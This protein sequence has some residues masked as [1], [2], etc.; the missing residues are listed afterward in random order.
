MNNLTLIIIFHV[1]LAPL[2]QLFPIVGTVHAWLIFSI[3][4]YYGLT[5]KTIDRL[6]LFTFY[7][8]GAELLWRGFGANVF[9]EFG[10][11]AILVNIIIII[12]RIGINSL[13]LNTGALYLLFLLPSILVIKQF[14]DFNHALLGP[15]VIG[16]SVLLY[17]QLKINKML[18]SKIILFTLLP[19]ITI[20]SITFW[21]TLNSGAFDFTSAYIHRVE[22]GGVGPNQMSNI[23]GLGSLLS[24]IYYIFNRDTPKSKYFLIFSIM[25]LTQTILT[26]SRGGFYNV[27]L[28]ISIYYYFE[29]STQKNKLKTLGSIF[30]I[31][32][33]LNFILFPFLDN[34]SG[35]SIMNRFSDTNISSREDIILSEFD[36]FKQFPIFGIGP[37]QSRKYRL[38]KYGNY[39]HSHTEYTRL[40]AEHG[41]L[42]ILALLTLISIVLQNYVNKR[43]IR[44]SVSLALLGWS[45]IFMA[46]SGTRL[47][48]PCILFGFATANFTFE[49]EES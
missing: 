27:G 13:V 8:V 38:E 46:H 6:L 35:G 34:M 29:I 16:F 48:A 49:K 41:I 18:F 9:W 24:F 10:K 28:A 22:T 26:H 32:L 47:V 44:R 15:I 4:L 23:L 43:G 25:T 14:S 39:K 11:I 12:F 30:S 17:S 5:D 33:F 45:L 31:F 21:D 42:G 40:I 3:G 19:I 20:F 2:I 7:I 36:A 1:I 37:G